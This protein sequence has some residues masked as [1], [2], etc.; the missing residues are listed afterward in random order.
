VRRVVILG[1]GPVGLTMANKL[2]EQLSVLVLSPSNPIKFRSAPDSDFVL[3]PS[4]ESG[5]LFGNAVHWGSQHESLDIPSAS[6]PEFSDLPGFPFDLNSL[7]EYQGELLIQG[8]P[9]ITRDKSDNQ[10][11]FENLM[12]TSVF[13]GKSLSPF[14]K[15]IESGVTTIKSNFNTISFSFNSDLSIH[16]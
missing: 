3:H 4:S 10:L 7:K 1:A 11:E 14:P 12:K 5:T 9:P 16:R 6:A 15:R 2:S 8:W 13:Q